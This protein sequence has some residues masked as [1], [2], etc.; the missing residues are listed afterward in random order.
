MG[1]ENRHALVSMT[2]KDVY[3]VDRQTAK[4]LMSRM[5]EPNSWAASYEATDAKSGAEISI[6]IANVSSV[7]IPKE[8]HNA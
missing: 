6:T 5:A 7:V 1:Y 3:F 2:N 8:V 4:E